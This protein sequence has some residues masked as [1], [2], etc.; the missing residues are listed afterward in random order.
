M[1]SNIKQ[2]IAK[3]I[4][5]EIIT[6]GD[7]RVDN[8]SWLKDK[9]NPE[10]IKYLEEENSYAES[11]MADTKELREK[12]YNEIISRIKEDD[13]SCPY[14]REDYLYYFKEKKGK[15]YKIHFRKKPEGNAQEKLILDENKIAEG[16]S[17]C[18]VELLP[19]PNNKILAYTIDSVGDFSFTTF[20][21]NLDT[22]EILKDVLKKALVHEWANDNKH[23][24]YVIYEKG[25]RGKQLFIH[26]LG[27]EQN[28]DKLIF[29]E[30]DDKFGLWPRKTASKKY[31]IIG[32]GDFT[33]SE[34][35]Y[36]LADGSDIVLKIIEKREEGVM[37]VTEHRGEDFYFH[38]NFRALNYRIM[39]SP[40]NAH[41]RKN[42]EE[43]I[44]EKKGIKI[45]GFLFFKDF[46]VI[47]E[48]ELGLLKVK[49]LNLKNNSEHYINFPEETYTPW[50]MDNY[51][52]DT[53]F[54]R[55]RYSSL[56]TPRSWFD[57]NMES[58]ENILL[59]QQEVLGG[60]NKEDYITERKFAPAKDGKLIPITL[61]YKKGLKLND[62]NPLHLY[63]YGSYGASTQVYFNSTE[64]TLLNRGF[65]Y[66]IAHVRGGGELGE[67]WYND[68][69]LLNKTNTFEDF[70][71]CA[72]FLIK[73][74]YTY[75]GGIC[76]EGI[77]A[78]GTLMGAVA[79]M[80]PDLF[81]CIIGKVPAVDVLNNLFDSSIDNSAAH[82]GE[83]GNPNIKEHYDYLKSYSPYENVREQEYP[84]MLL[85]TG[86]NDANVPYWESVKFTAKLREF[87]KGD[88]F[89]ILKTEF[90]TA[91]FGPSGRY[92]QY[93]E[94]AYYYAFI[95][96]CFGIRE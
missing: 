30:E 87:N 53:K 32:T 12:L 74:G 28:D 68:G 4:P 33:T 57:H 31:I 80:R 47:T 37:Y 89:I 91:H 69:K 50:I 65:V 62:E 45:E 76:A 20:F 77:S 35:Y 83:L 8:Y 64:F 46:T 90:E 41:S 54:L 13:T 25:N 27:K 72:E 82:F 52:Y 26:S 94:A 85:T 51:E 88:N 81:K 86:L 55:F 49:V 59:K 3:K 44:P 2:P 17:Y 34:E 7:K 70:I 43:F 29:Q 40:V 75:Q 39:K 22:G 60:Y 84:K 48:R 61:V 73:E 1:K 92:D 42:W 79:N 23:V 24:Y 93:R 67:E 5:V 21:K 38:T 66:A 78:G 11:V 36:I 18:R 56:T 14:R 96:K 9:S 10:V 16:L 19:S 58:G 95:L 71:A 63:A 6:H 15:N